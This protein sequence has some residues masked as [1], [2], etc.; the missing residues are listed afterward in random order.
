LAFLKNISNSKLSD[1][2]LTALYRQT[3]D[4]K[5][6]G[7]LYERYLDL[8]YGVCLKYLRDPEKAKDSVMAIFEELIV[9]LKKHEVIYFKTWVHI[10]AK[11]HCLMQLRSARHFRSQEMDP[12]RMQLKEELHQYDMPEKE[13]DLKQLAKCMEGL[14]PEQKI[15]VELFYLQGKCYNEITSLTGLDWNQVRS[16]IQN[17]RRNLKICLEQKT[18]HQL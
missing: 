1:N 12:D 14:P 10:L 7:A 4:L 6:L 3:G 17:G 9:K 13:E 15:T 11:N 8:L 18:V 5:V 2:E 16:H